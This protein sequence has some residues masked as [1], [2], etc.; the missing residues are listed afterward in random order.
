M[1]TYGRRLFAPLFALIFA[2]VAMYAPVSAAETSSSKYKS[3]KAALAAKK[4]KAALAAKKKRALANKKLPRKKA[5]VVEEED[6]LDEA[7]DEAG[8][9]SDELASS[10]AQKSDDTMTGKDLAMLSS[11]G[12]S[13]DDLGRS[14]NSSD[15][16]I[17]SARSEPKGAGLAALQIAAGPRAFGRILRWNDD[18]FQRMV[19]YQVA[20]AFAM[21]LTLDWF[22]AA[23]FTSGVLA[24]IGLTGS[25]DMA[26]GLGTRSADGVFPTQA[27]GFDVGLQFRL[28]FNGWQLGAVGAYGQQNF[29][30]GNAPAVRSTLPPDVAYNFIRAGAF[31]RFSLTSALELSLNAEY[32]LVQSSGMIGSADY[33]P[34]ASAAGV[35]AGLGID[36]YF[37]RAFGVG[38]SGGIRRYFFNMNSQPGDANV[39]GG[40]IDQYPVGMFKILYRM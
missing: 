7:S 16:A 8:A 34:R 9:Q 18:L 32:L 40:A 13:R 27:T 39:A 28:P 22:P 14:R 26:L 33:F 2:L 24:N 11:P 20:P 36:W 37:S 15:D 4:K 17:A 1:S 19:G 30:I 31:G 3:K 25:Y 23:H 35:G 12:T 21:G 5:K 38:L 29:A 10:S 6:S